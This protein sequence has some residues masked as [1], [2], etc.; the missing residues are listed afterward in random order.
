MI[1]K[2]VTFFCYLQWSVIGGRIMYLFFILML[3]KKN[4]V[5]NILRQS[6]GIE[7]KQLRVS[8]LFALALK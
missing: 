2:Q 4:N 6:G 8:F 3:L 1:R 5:V 7:Q